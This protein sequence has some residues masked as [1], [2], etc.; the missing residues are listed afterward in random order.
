MCVC[1]CA[2]AFI[3]L[4]VR[5]WKCVEKCVGDVG[6]CVF[7]DGVGVDVWVCVGVCGCGRG[8]TYTLLLVFLFR[9]Y[10]VYV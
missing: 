8:D 1:A 9:V 5:V 2:R 7:I 6:W 10:C 4:G 3:G